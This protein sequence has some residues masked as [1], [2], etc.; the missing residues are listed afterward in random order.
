MSSSGAKSR[1]TAR[2]A[3]GNQASRVPAAFLAPAQK[4]WPVLSLERL[5]RHHDLKIKTDAI[6]GR[7]QRACTSELN[8][9][10]VY[11]SST[12]RP[13]RMRPRATRKR[14]R[15]CLFRSLSLT[16]FARPAGRPQMLCILDTRSISYI[17]I[18]CSSARA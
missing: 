9:D 4:G 7:A 2:N 1:Q 8:A 10:S 6:I 14:S 15:P 11:M 16:R 12:D 3:A 13:V 17:V 5:Q 18:Y